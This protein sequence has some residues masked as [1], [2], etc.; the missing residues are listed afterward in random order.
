M[1]NRPL[2][3]KDALSALKIETDQVRAQYADIRMRMK[4]KAKVTKAERSFVKQIR[5]RGR[6]IGAQRKKDAFERL[7][8]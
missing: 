5:I 2:S 4:I 3:D 8:S 1:D 7:F 6:E